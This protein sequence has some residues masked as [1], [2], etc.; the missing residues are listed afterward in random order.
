MVT[1]RFVCWLQAEDPIGRRQD[2]IVI[3]IPIVARVAVAEMV[4]AATAT[5]DTAR[6][7]LAVVVTANTAS[8]AAVP[9]EENLSL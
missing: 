3:D 5:A 1:D 2:V 6:G 4:T 9:T 7:D 8:T